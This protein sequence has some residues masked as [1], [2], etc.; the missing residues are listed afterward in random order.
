MNDIAA[1]LIKKRKATLADPFWHRLGRDGLSKAKDEST[2]ASLFTEVAQCEAAVFEN[3]QFLLH[4]YM[5]TRGYSSTDIDHYLMNGLLVRIV[6]DTYT[7]YT[8]LLWKVRE[9]QHTHRQQKKV[10]ILC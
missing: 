10:I 5:A 6:R 9:L 4:E 2:F 7:F 8:R 1:A 3:Q